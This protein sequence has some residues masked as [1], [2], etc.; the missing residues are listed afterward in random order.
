MACLDPA[1]LLSIKSCKNCGKQ[2]WE[3]EVVKSHTFGYSEFKSQT[4]CFSCN[5]KNDDEERLSVL[6]P[7][8]A[9]CSASKFEGPLPYFSSIEQEQNYKRLLAET[10]ASFGKKSELPRAGKVKKSDEVLLS[11][12]V[13]KTKILMRRRLL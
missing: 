11:Y 10:R 8:A 4:Y 6:F 2:L 12:L 13:T 7:E 5:N 9:S 3:D 1:Y